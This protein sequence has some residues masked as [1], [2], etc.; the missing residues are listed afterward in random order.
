[1]DVPMEFRRKTERKTLE[2]KNYKSGDLKIK[3]NET[4]FDSKRETYF[5]KK[6]NSK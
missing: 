1:M 4:G 2:R 6:N 3:L 5:M